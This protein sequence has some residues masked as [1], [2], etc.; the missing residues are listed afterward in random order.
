MVK[1]IHTI[2]KEINK[3]PMKKFYI[4][5][6]LTILSAISRSMDDAKRC[7]G[8]WYDVLCFR[9]SPKSFCSTGLMPTLLH[10]SVRRVAVIS[11]SSL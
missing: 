3:I 4:A 10:T 8:L 9:C 2:F 5:E 11:R 6:R 1:H 7:C